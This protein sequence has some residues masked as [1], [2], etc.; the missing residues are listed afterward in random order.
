MRKEPVE[1]L[2]SMDV[3]GTGERRPFETFLQGVK[4]CVPT[5]LGY[6]SIGFAAGVVERTAGLSLAEIALLCLL[7]YAGS[8]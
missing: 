2:K 8:A 7:L 1:S 4:D 5:L 3:Q 6:W